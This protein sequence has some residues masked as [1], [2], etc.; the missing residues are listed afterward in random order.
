M[1]QLETTDINRYEFEHV[2]Y[3]TMKY[4]YFQILEC[5]LYKNVGPLDQ[6]WSNE[7]ERKYCSSTVFSFRK[8]K[9]KRAFALFAQMSGCVVFGTFNEYIIW[10]KNAKRLAHS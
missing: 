3:I 4:E 7:I 6:D 1:I 10:C 9:H 5:W 2:T 8:H